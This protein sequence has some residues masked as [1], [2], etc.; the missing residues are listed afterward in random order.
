[1]AQKTDA[2][3]QKWMNSVAKSPEFRSIYN[4]GAQD[5][6]QDPRVHTRSVDPSKHIPPLPPFQT[7]K[8]K[9]LQAHATLLTLQMASNARYKKHDT[10]DFIKSLRKAIKTKDLHCV[11]QTI[12]GQRIARAQL[13]NVYLKPISDYSQLPTVFNR[14]DSP[15]RWASN[16]NFDL[17]LHSRPLPKVPSMFVLE[18][19]FNPPVHSLAQIIRRKHSSAFKLYKPPLDMPQTQSMRHSMS[20]L[21][22]SVLNDGSRSPRSYYKSASLVTNQRPS[23][24]V[25]HADDSL[26]KSISPSQPL[27]TVNL[28]SVF[29]SANETGPNTHT[30]RQK[31][32][33]FAPGHH[34][35]ASLQAT[36]AYTS[37]M[38]PAKPNGI[39]SKVDRCFSVLSHSSIS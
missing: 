4:N 29:E 7:E 9:D 18:G 15:K 2:R 26:M 11:K 38:L 1:M 3:R 32:S 13:T 14:R 23:Q 27:L 28:T 33:L 21:G 8:D 25:T 5:Y 37:M 34:S 39:P 35:V 22:H 24:P 6:I 31:R 36:T 17:N 19:S 10:A 20:Q 12:E 16:S 30:R